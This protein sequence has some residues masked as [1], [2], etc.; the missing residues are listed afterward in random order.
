LADNRRI[1][2]DFSGSKTDLYIGRAGWQRHQR[3][4]SA[5]AAKLAHVAQILCAWLLERRFPES[6][7]R[8]ETQLNLAIQNNAA[9]YAA[10]EK[11]AAVTRKRSS[12]NVFALPGRKISSETGS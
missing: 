12:G 5:K 6:F 3:S 7:L 9:E 4:R 2:G 8:P 11:Q 10:I 1:S